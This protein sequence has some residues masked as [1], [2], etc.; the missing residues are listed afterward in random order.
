MSTTKRLFQD[1]ATYSHGA[2]LIVAV[3]AKPY[4]YIF[5]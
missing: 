1:K 2:K 3:F 5:S 4:K